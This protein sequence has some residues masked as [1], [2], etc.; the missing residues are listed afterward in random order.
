MMT[1]F[2]TGSIRKRIGS[3]ESTKSKWGGNSRFLAVSIIT[4]PL[5]TLNMR[6]T[7]SM[8]S[9]VKINTIC[10]ECESY[11]DQDNCEVCQ[12]YLW[13]EAWQRCNS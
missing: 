8:D 1:I 10:C 6:E 12:E 7:E 3:S 2:L 5:L 13:H 11:E 4:P 9:D